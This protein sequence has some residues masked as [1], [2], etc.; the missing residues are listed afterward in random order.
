MSHALKSPGAAAIVSFALFVLVAFAP[1]MARADGA[2]SS[3]DRRAA[4]DAY[5]KG[6]ARYLLRDYAGAAEWFELADRLA[7]DLSALQSAIR[8][9]KQIGS[10]PHA[11]RAAT[12]ALRL[13][14]RAPNDAA[15]N[16][17]ADDVIAG[18]SS[19]LG[20]I[21]VR[22]HG[23]Q[24][25]VDGVLEAAPDLFAIPGEHQIVGHW[26]TGQKATKS[27]D[28]RAGKNEV[29]DWMVVE[30]V[31]S[32]PAQATMPGSALAV[33]DLPGDPGKSSNGLPPVIALSGAALTAVLGGATAIS[34]FADAVPA[35]NKLIR[36]AEST[37]TSDPAQEDRVH[38]AETRTTVLL[39][40]TACTAA[41]SLVVGLFFTRWSGAPREVS[42]T[43]RASLF[44]ASF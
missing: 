10:A 4:A 18:A 26:P 15:A 31:A 32:T 13:K 33:H 42:G 2:P 25:E 35:G 30:A 16:R 12:L 43:A 36:D 44:R 38:A 34:W 29:V 41:A 37:H 8:A 9:H 5:D 7:P 21:T 27:V 28:A 39:A 23:C 11:A 3:E 19:S 1:G 24:I 40:A 22:C 20:R 17:S 6:S 14:V